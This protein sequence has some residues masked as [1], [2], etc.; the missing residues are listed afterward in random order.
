MIVILN[1]KCEVNIS[2]LRRE[3]QFYQAKSMLGFLSSLP[4]LSNRLMEGKR[5]SYER[6]HVLEFNFRSGG[7]IYRSHNQPTSPLNTFVAMFPWIVV[8]LMSWNWLWCREYYTYSLRQAEID[9]S[10]WK[11]LG[12]D[13]FANFFEGFGFGEFCLGKKVSISENLFPNKSRFR[14]I[15][16]RK[17]SIVFGFGKFRIGKKVLVSVSVKILILSFIANRVCQK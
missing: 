16:S 9:I 1:I 2:T 4:V 8:L 5:E 6:Q 10:V 3:I 13:T 17:R 12:F 7:N 11:P 14:R 15:W